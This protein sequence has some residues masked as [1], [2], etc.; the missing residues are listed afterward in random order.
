MFSLEKRINIL[1]I[2][3]LFVVV[4]AVILLN[5][6]FFQRTITQ[7]LIQERLPT[8][9]QEILSAIDKKIMEPSRA[10]SLMANNQQ[11][12]NWVRTGESNDELDSIYGILTSFIQSYGMLGANFVSDATK[13]YT[14]YIEGRRDYSYSITDKD[15]WF[16][17]FKNSNMDMNIV[18][19]VGDPKWGTKAF[20]NRRVTVDGKFAGLAS[21]S[22]D[23][24]NFAQQLGQMKIGKEGL[25]FLVDEKGFIRLHENTS[26][27]NKHIEEV[28][29]NYKKLWHTIASK[30][31]SQHSLERAGDTFYSISNKIPMLN[32][33][34]INEASHSENTQSVREATYYG[35]GL[36][37]VLTLIGML[38][39]MYFVRGIVRPLRQLAHFANEVSHGI[40]DKEL[41]IQRQ[42][43]IGVL[44]DALRD[45]V[46]S[47]KQKI[48]QAEEQGQQM[49]EQMTIAQ[50][51]REYSD[52]QQKK[53]SELLHA[54]QESAAQAANI[55]ST[56]QSAVGELSQENSKVLSST[57]IQSARMQEA[58]TAVSTMVY[59]FKDILES[60]ENAMVQE[61][62]ARTI[63]QM[64]AQKVTA[65]MDANHT[66]R[67][68]AEKMR[69]TMQ[70]LQTQTQG[71]SAIVNT[72]TDIADQTNLLALNAAIEAARA[73]EA[74]RG[75]AVVADEVRKLAE[76]TMYATGE[77]A[78]AI[79]KVQDASTESDVIMED[80][81]KAIQN[82]TNLAQ[83]SSGALQN[84]V[85]LTEENAVKVR[86]IA[87]MVNNLTTQT[88]AINSALAS[89]E[90]NITNT[91][92]GMDI[93]SNITYTIMDETQKL[94]T[95]IVALNSHKA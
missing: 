74:G 23:L 80:T 29:P 85:H 52:A 27:V 95:L 39:G 12:Q 75:F 30:N 54:T 78:N 57:H 71:I 3:L 91:A 55:S 33:Y 93:S 28:Y 42:D 67:D 62:E 87:H 37:V 51:A 89:L 34:L 60:T 46:A 25:T 73:G 58:T 36:S 26:Y 7:Q 38:I 15:A 31:S 70:G 1:I 5:S 40:L 66:V 84:I 11:L 59:T 48:E 86:S 88:D 32:W 19:Y 81:H 47:L 53:T 79:T 20:I 45:M 56:L 35:I 83:D 61:D 49:L 41:H 68:M 63:A 16:Y 44:A 92:H 77:V 43:E 22:L 72:I 8:M 50:K 6:F 2:S 24:E 17:N 82:A 90:E 65:V 64:G 94:N 13:Q 4:S 76:K 69:L 21:S 14:D 18:V 10:I 9:A